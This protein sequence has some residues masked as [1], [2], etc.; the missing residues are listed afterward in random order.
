M[1]QRNADHVG[2]QMRSVQKKNHGDGNGPYTYIYGRALP[3]THTAQNVTRQEAAT[4]V[5][6]MRCSPRALSAGRAADFQRLAN[7]QKG[8]HLHSENR[9]IKTS[10]CC[11]GTGCGK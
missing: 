2:S 10:S 6:E 1:Q 3:A 9:E 5:G 11:V 7:E 4:K 8:N